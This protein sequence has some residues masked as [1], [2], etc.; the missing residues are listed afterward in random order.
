MKKAHCLD[1][2]DFIS[3]KQIEYNLGIDIG[4]VSMFW[5]DV[6]IRDYIDNNGIWA[7]TIKIL[8]A[9]VFHK[10]LQI[11]DPAFRVTNVSPNLSH[12]LH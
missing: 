6:L 4:I 5:G 1:C 7:K 2:G 3:P 10:K 12:F 9:K 11:P 8:R